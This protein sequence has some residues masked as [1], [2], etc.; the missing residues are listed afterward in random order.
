[1]FPRVPLRKGR[2]PGHRD[3]LLHPLYQCLRQ[4][5][6][7]WVRPAD[8]NHPRAP[9]EEDLRLPH[10]GQTQINDNVMDWVFFKAEDDETS[11]FV[12]NPNI[13]SLLSKRTKRNIH[14]SIMFNSASVLS[15]CLS[16]GGAGQPD[17]GG[18]QHRVCSSQSH[19]A[20]RLLGRPHH[21]PHPQTPED[22]QVG[23][24]HHSAGLNHLS[25]VVYTECCCI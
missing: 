6:S 13:F 22:E 25:L 9:P 2:R 16:S 10:S 8:R 11:R 14:I 7:E 24:W 18:R 12:C 20:S 19:H 23:V 1:M 17:A 4:A 15:P 5:G 21:L 3:R